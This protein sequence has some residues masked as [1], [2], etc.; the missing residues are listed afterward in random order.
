LCSI[1][2]EEQYRIQ[3]IQPKLSDNPLDVGDIGKLR[4]VGKSSF[5][6]IRDRNL[7]GASGRVLA[8]QRNGRSSIKVHGA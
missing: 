4:Q 8:T 2:S 6:L 7:Q 3:W 5:Y 1:G